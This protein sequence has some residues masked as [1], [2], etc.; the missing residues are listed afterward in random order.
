[1]SAIRNYGRYAPP[2]NDTDRSWSRM[3]RLDRLRATRRN[4]WIPRWNVTR[5]PFDRSLVFPDF[6][7]STLP[8]NSTKIRRFRA[9]FKLSRTSHFYVRHTSRFDEYWFTVA[10]GCCTFSGKVN[11]VARYS[12]CVFVSAIGELTE[13]TGVTRLV[14]TRVHTEHAQRSLCHRGLLRAELV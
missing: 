6:R 4:G 11:G 3:S 2:C 12:T 14:R 10:S 7:R 9:S 1:M 5:V 13:N 8:S